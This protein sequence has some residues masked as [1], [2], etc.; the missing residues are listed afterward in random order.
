[1]PVAD[2]R[3]HGEDAFEAAKRLREGGAGGARAGGD[4]DVKVAQRRLPPRAVRMPPHQNVAPP[5]VAV[6]E[7]GVGFRV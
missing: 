1:M 3:R 4:R 2:F 7:P 6:Y 5:H